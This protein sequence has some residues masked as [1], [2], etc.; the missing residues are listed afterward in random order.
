MVFDPPV[1]LPVD[2][3]FEP[4]AEA[5]LSWE[6]AEWVWRGGRVSR[7]RCWVLTFRS[8]AHLDT[9]VYSKTVASWLDFL[10]ERLAAEFVRQG[11]AAR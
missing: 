1:E 8:T 10:A 3:V 4:G 2:V 5:N 7:D 9:Q 11:E 6:L